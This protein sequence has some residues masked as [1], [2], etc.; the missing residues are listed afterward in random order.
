[1][2][3]E[4]RTDEVAAGRMDSDWF[5]HLSRPRRLRLRLTNCRNRAWRHISVPCEANIL[6]VMRCPRRGFLCSWPGL[7]C[8][9]AESRE[10]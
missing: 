8:T 1:M 3:V 4:T 9:V 2:S 7:A 10:A 5:E 6:P